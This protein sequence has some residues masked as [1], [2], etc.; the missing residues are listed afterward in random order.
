MNFEIIKHNFECGLWTAQ[1]V[2]IA[3]KKDI[4]TKEQYT[5][6]TGKQY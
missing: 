3:V 1:M 4:I 5:Q 2:R 6:I